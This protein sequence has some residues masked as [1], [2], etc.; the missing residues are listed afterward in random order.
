MLLPEGYKPWVMRERDFLSLVIQHEAQFYA[1]WM[2]VLEL[3]ELSAK[4]VE[5]FEMFQRLKAGR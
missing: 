3:Y 2:D 4:A 1:Q 5:A